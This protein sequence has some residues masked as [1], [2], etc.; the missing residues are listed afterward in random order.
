MWRSTGIITSDS[1]GWIARGPLLQNL[2]TTRATSTVAVR[3]TVKSSLLVE[4]LTFK[5]KR[6][7]RP[8]SAEIPVVQKF[9]YFGRSRCTIFCKTLH[10]LP[11]AIQS[12]ML[13]GKLACLQLSSMV[14]PSSK[15]WQS[16][17]IRLSMTQRVEASGPWSSASP[18][19]RIPRG[20]HGWP[21]V[22]GFHTWRYL[23]MDSFC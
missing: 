7:N 4:P 13:M 12:Q 17:K 9:L 14:M 2:L 11:F 18:A 19:R 1:N 8:K 22:A 6:F 3:T 23:K 15:C 16:G 20:G 5:M 21:Q 10:N